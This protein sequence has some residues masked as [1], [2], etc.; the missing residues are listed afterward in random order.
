MKRQ[1]LTL[2]LVGWVAV[3]WQLRMLEA[4]VLALA[5]LAGAVAL[6]TVATGAASGRH[7]LGRLLSWLERRVAP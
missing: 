4:A 2:A 1:I 3:L 6:L 7:A 5:F